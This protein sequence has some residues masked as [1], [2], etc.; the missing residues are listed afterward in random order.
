MVTSSYQLW[1]LQIKP[2]V[3]L[4]D[5][6][7]FKV[8]WTVLN[9]LRAH[10]DRFN[11]TVNKIDL[12]K[13]KPGNIL[14]GRPEYSFDENGN[15]SLRDLQGIT[16]TWGDSSHALR[17]VTKCGLCP[18]GQEGGRSKV[19]GAVGAECREIAERQVK[20]SHHLSSR[21]L[22]RQAFKSFMTG[23]HKNINP[24]ISQEEAIEMLSQH[25]ITRPV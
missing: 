7:R 8:V 10:D 1:C 21:R 4:Q 23:L 22:P 16:A 2:E 18:H 12:N 19:L 3:A 20:R 25:I 17:G 9:A 13:R 5:N 14:V 15:M 24:S 6:E 11:A